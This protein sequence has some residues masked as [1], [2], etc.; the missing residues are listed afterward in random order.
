MHTSILLFALTSFAA[1][2]EV[3]EVPSWQND[4]AQAQKL[5]TTEGKPL[6]IFMS[7]G[8]AGYNKLS[9]DGELEGEVKQLL[10]AKY[11]CVYL[12]TTSEY[13]KQ[14]A[15]SFEMPTGLGI[16]ISDRTGGMQAFRHEGDLSASALKGYLQRFSDPSLVVRST[17]S[18]PGN[19]ERTSN[20]YNPG[21][22]S[23]SQGGYCPTCSGCSG[24]RC[25]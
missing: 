10:T 25:R 6:A 8:K 15:S 24:G 19:E 14:L 11:V 5:G 20:Y 9:R 23:G 17:V 18:N 16:V 3:A 4:Y 13:G 7:T 12:D 1:P 21:S 2:A 22:G